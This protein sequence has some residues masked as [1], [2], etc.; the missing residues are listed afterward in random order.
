M[1]VIGLDIGGTK[2]AGGIVSF[3][4]GEV[5]GRRVIPTRPE[6]PGEE[7][8]AD[9]VRFARE[10]ASEAA[11]GNLA[12]AGIGA[13]VAELVDHDG[14]VTLEVLEAADTAARTGAAAVVKSRFRAL[15]LRPEELFTGERHHLHDHTRPPEE[16]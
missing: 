3:P 7:V 16:Q 5:S 8:L 9:L 1:H 4:G 2:I 11:R 15:D 10:L 6:R 14:N 12:I 13:G